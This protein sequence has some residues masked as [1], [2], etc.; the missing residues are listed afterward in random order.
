MQ[1]DGINYIAIIAATIVAFVIGAVFY[2]TLAKQWMKA[3]KIPE[4]QEPNMKPSL[5]A[6]T[7][8]CQ[9]VLAFMIAGVVGHL[10]EGQ[11]T[12]SN[13]F[14]SGFFLWLGIIMPTMTI[15]HRYQDFGWDLTII[16]GLHWLLVACAMGSVIGW[17]GV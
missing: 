12:L 6:I 9:L 4:G 1:F 16:D 13:G 5:F 14:I 15:N 2:S 3:V 7:F 17:F 10:G 8:F 11:V